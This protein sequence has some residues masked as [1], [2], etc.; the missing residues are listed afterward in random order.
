M[1]TIESM[2]HEK[3]KFHPSDEFK[4]AAHIKSLEEYNEIYKRSI[5]DPE[6]FWAEKAEQ[7]DWFRKWDSVFHY[8][9]KPFVK[10]FDGG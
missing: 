9:E 1:A 7:I 8:T 10:W 6:A 3:R 5:Q 2:A 4:A